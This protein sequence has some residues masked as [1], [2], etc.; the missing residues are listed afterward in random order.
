M[1]FKAT[2]D[3]F[4]KFAAQ[5]IRSIKK[6]EIVDLPEKFERHPKLEAVKEEPVKKKVVKK[7]VAKKAT[8]KTTKKFW[9]K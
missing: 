2:A 8:K 9:N 6:G 3:F 4:F 7:K 1:K 5:D